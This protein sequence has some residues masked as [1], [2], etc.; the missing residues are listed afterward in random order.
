MCIFRFDSPLLF[1]NVEAFNGAVHE[2]VANWNR[3]VKLNRVQTAPNLDNLLKQ[4]QP[5]K[6]G[7]GG[8]GR[9]G[10]GGGG[11]RNNG[12]TPTAT[13]TL[14]TIERQLTRRSL[15]DVHISGSSVEVCFFFQIPKDNFA[16]FSIFKY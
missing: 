10:G 12:T 1:T 8:A 13:L 14:P 15:E 5:S 6:G 2:T 11:G 4:L 3:E 7:G 16:A 9:G